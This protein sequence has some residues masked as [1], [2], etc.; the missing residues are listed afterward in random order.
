MKTYVQNDYLIFVLKLLVS[1]LFLVP[2]NLFTTMPCEIRNSG[3]WS[4]ADRIVCENQDGRPNFYVHIMAKMFTLFQPMS[5]I[6]NIMIP[7]GTWN[8]Y[9][10]ISSA[11]IEQNSRV[12]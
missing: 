7:W 6:F 5:L 8:T 9:T 12:P 1:F 2:N 4:P 3:K 10:K 11:F